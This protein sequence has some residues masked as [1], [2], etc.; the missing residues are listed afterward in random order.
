MSIEFLK[1]LSVQKLDTIARI[2]RSTT[3]LINRVEFVNYS[4][5]VFLMS[6]KLA[7]SSDTDL[8]AKLPMQLIDR[9][10]IL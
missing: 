6:T 2:I 1:A 4:P 10:E 9:L 5:E 7:K 8:M 3:P